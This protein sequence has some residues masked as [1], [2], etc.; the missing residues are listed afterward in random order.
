MAGVRG[1]RQRA[2]SLVRKPCRVCKGDEW[3]ALAPP[4]APELS[5]AVPCPACGPLRLPT[6]PTSGNPTPTQET[7]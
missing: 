6:V 3:V 1:T 7:T 4:L 5:A 2:L